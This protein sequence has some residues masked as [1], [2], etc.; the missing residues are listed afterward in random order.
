MPATREK[1][2]Q[3]IMV[4]VEDYATVFLE[5]T[6]RD[7]IFVLKSTFYSVCTDGSQAHR[8]VLVF[9]NRRRLVGTLSFRDVIGS[10]KVPEDSPK[11]WEGLLRKLCLFHAGMRVKE[12]MK[13]V[14]KTK[15]QAHD[16]IISAIYLLINEDLE[17]VP[18]EEN[19][20]IVGMIRSVEIFKEVS[21]IVES[22]NFS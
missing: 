21:E 19:G 11:H 17:L 22:N 8:S 4:P 15:V 1:R 18:V 9:D 16:S 14:G 5:N 3:D 6:L 20:I 13:P 2:V 10:F 12:I 7:A